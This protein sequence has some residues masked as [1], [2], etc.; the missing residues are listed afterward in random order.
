MAVDVRPTALTNALKHAGG[1][2]AWVTVRYT[3]TALEL[4]VLD[5][6]AG[7]GTGG[8]GGNWLVGTQERVAM[9]GGRVEMGRRREGGWALRARLPVG[10]T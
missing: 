5:D 4:E 8:G 2:H 6:G 1:T 10:S 3:D 7:S 9:Y